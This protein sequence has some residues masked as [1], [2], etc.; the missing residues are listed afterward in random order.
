MKDGGVGWHEL[1]TSDWQKAFDF[2]GGQFGWMKS[3]AMDMGPMGTYQ[4]FKPV[5]GANDIGG[6]MTLKDT[7]KPYWLFYFVV[8]DIDDAVKRVTSH[9]GTVM[10]GPMEVPGGAWVIQAT[11]P[12]GAM[13][14]LVG[15]RK[16][17]ASS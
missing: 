4:L 8:S 2:Y 13:F 12:Q 6:M 5:D 11:D 15:M 10:M 7:P 1:M 14:A 3:T 9:K 16:T 17:G